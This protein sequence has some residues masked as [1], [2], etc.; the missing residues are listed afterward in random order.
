[1]QQTTNMKYILIFLFIPFLSFSQRLDIKLINGVDHL[2]KQDTSENGVITIT[3]T[4]LSQVVKELES[5]VNSI[6]GAIETVDNEITRL[7]AL[8]KEY[9]LQLKQIQGLQSKAAGLK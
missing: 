5:Q 4:P 2:I 3:K 1:M 7:Q 8:K 6:N 9:N